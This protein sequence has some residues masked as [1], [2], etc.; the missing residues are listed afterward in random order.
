MDHRIA[1]VDD[2]GRYNF[3][4]SPLL[5]HG[6]D[7]RKQSSLKKKR[8]VYTSVLILLILPNTTTTTTSTTSYLIFSS[9][10]RLFSSAGGG[11]LRGIIIPSAVNNS[12]VEII[13]SNLFDPLRSITSDYYFTLSVVYLFLFYIFFLLFVFN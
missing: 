10:F 4:F 9:I 5:H 13:T 2:Y 8:S 3:K 7:E 1:L 11:R 12:A 6:K